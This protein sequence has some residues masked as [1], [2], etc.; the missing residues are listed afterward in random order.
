V[1]DAHD[2]QNLN[3]TT[4][5]E[6]DLDR[7]DCIVLGGGL[8]GLSIAWRSAQRGASVAVIERDEPG[9]SASWVAAGMLAPVTEADFG[10]QD[11]LRLNLESAKR[12]PAFVEE[13]SRDSGVPVELTPK[14]TIFVALN[15]DQS[16]ALERLHD[17]QESLG[18]EVERLDRASLRSLEPALHPSANS[19]VLARDDRAIDPRL[20]SRALI[21]AAR[22][23]GVH[24]ISNVNIS[25]LI[26][27]E[28]ICAGVRSDDRTEFF[29]DVVV[30]AAGSWSGSMGGAPPELVQSIRPVKGQLIHLRPHGSLPS[31][32]EYSIRT[33]DV[34]IVPRS[35]GSLVVGASVEE[36]GFDVAVT[37]GEMLDLLR[38][39]EEAVPAIRE[40]E[41]AATLA[42]LRPGTPDNA[43][44]LGPSSIEGVISATGHFRNGVLLTPVTAD[45]IAE[46]IS[47]GETPEEIKAFDP[48]RFG[49]AS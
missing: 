13:L 2:P 14:G 11:L 49:V 23:S 19:G 32:I 27:N 31:P 7:Y 18:L 12:Y 35:D 21:E 33:E 20:L 29:S 26:V 46:L 34:Y 6:G 4:P 47:T 44:L 30:I 9:K 40:M 10:E 1:G 36:K 16:E 24:L 15:R 37:A 39:A 45:A 41:L 25:S 42:G 43:P 8:I 17:F 5:A 22:I 28:G 38:S 48:K 3:R